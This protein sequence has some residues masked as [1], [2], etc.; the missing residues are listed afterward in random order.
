MPQMDHTLSSHF[1]DAAPGPYVDM[2]SCEI[3]NL[4]GVQT[5]E[6]SQATGILEGLQYLHQHRVVHGD[7]HW[8]RVTDLAIL[9]PN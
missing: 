4:L 3:V 1:F 7:L 9:Q 6:S 2:V 8:V 5:D